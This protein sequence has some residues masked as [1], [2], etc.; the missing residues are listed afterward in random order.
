[1]KLSKKIIYGVAALLAAS[2]LF[3]ACKTEEDEH[4]MIDGDS[5]EYENDG[6]SVTYARAFSSTRTKHLD[7]DCTITI[8]LTKSSGTYT[9]GYIFDLTE[10]AKGSTTTVGGTTVDTSGMYNF[11]LVGITYRDSAWKYFVS[12]YNDVPSSAVS[13]DA[14]DFDLDTRTTANP[15]VETS[16]VDWTVLNS[17]SAGAVY[18]DLTANEDGSYTVQLRN[19]T[20]DGTV[21]ATQTV[22]A[23]ITGLSEATQNKIAKYA[24]V[25]SASK[26]TG[27]WAYSNVSK[28]AAGEAMIWND[29][30]TN[31]R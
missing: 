1:M 20:A 19:G 10:N 18:I 4:G 11:G 3:S 6:S 28:A 29:E 7:A 25:K 27:T 30:I 22:S 24:M 13:S 21:L 16:I 15:A 9:M 14:N 23:A 31:V 8:D 5:I 26:L 17:V 12:F 2:V